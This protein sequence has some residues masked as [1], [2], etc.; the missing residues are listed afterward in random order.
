MPRKSIPMALVYDF[1]GTLGPGNLQENSFIPEV[2]M[3]NDEFW[4]E[5]NCLSAKLQADSVLM[6]MYLMLDRA[7]AKKVPVRLDDFKKRGADVGFFNGVESWF[8]RIRDYGNAKGVN[9]EHR[10]VSSGNAEIIEGT[11]IAKHFKR[12]YGSRF[13]YDENGAACWP[14]LAINFTTKTQFLFRINKGAHDLSDDQSINRFVPM[15]DRPVPFENMV[16]IGDGETDVPC[17]R[18][19]KELGGLSVAVFKPFTKNA[20]RK[21]EQ[22]A[23]DGRVHCVAPA[24]YTEG[25]QLDQVVKR[26]IDLLAARETRNKFL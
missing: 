8:D 11:T 24:D 18:L 6:Y 22:F 25:G 3:S 19:V 21:A 12:I 1:D 20:R 14:A 17:F 13:M 23:K 10:I 2:G 7:N 26:Q 15:D 9:V 5:V 16:Y 4:D